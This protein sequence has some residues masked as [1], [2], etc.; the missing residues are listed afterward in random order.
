MALQAQIDHIPSAPCLYY[1]IPIII[2]NL[3]APLPQARCLIYF[4]YLW[5]IN[6]PADIKTL[7]PLILPSIA[8]SRP[9][10]PWQSST[11]VDSKFTHTLYIK[12]LLVI[13][14]TAKLKAKEAI[15]IRNATIIKKVEI[16]KLA[17][18]GR[19]FNIARNNGKKQVFKTAI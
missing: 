5:D 13:K 4:G 18:S 11:I 7:W 1:G 10:R 19:K 17:K 9:S 16:R 8:L 2:L 12:T 15:N 14:E 6:S 3:L